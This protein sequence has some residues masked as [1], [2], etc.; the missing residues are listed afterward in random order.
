ML[1]QYSTHNAVLSQ[2]VIGGL[3]VDFIAKG[4]RKTLHVSLIYNTIHP[5]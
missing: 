1:T 5:H 2:V 3:N 4:K